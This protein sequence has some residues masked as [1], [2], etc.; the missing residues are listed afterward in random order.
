MYNQTVRSGRTSPCCLTFS[1]ICRSQKT[2]LWRLVCSTF[3]PSERRNQSWMSGTKFRSFESDM[4]HI[5]KKINVFQRSL[6]NDKFRIEFLV[7]LKEIIRQVWFTSHLCKVN[8]KSCWRYAETV[9]L[10]YPYSPAGT[11]RVVSIERDKKKVTSK[12]IYLKKN[13]QEEPT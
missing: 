11:L 3:S 4:Q 9:Y 8:V 7:F 5:K 1:P 6:L 12:E 13:R 10:W 2:T